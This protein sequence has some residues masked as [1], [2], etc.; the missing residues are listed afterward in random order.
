[1]KKQPIQSA[2]SLPPSPDAERKVRMLKYT[3][4]MVVRLICFLVAALLYKQ[5]GW[6][7]LI[8]VVAAVLLPYIAVV[9][10]NTVI[11]SAVTPVERPGSLVPLSVPHTPG[12]DG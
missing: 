8:P 7:T 11:Q 5:L 1:M 6:W 9:V 3:I 2:T 4:A 12:A 10:A